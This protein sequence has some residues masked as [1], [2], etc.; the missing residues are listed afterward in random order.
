TFNLSYRSH[1]FDYKDMAEG[2]QFHYQIISAAIKE[3]LLQKPKLLEL[4]L[5]TEDLELI[6]D[7]K[8]GKNK[9]KSYFYNQILMDIRDTYQLKE[10]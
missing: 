9:P 4:L 1:F 8:I 5:S 6:P 10:K 3:K 2:S 7:H